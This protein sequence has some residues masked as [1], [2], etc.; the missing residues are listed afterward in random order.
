MGKLITMPNR[1]EERH[2]FDLFNQRF[3]GC[4]DEL[5]LQEQRERM[6]E[7]AKEVAEMLDRLDGELS[8]DRERAI[9]M[10]TECTGLL[11][12]VLDDIRCIRDI[13]ESFG[14]GRGRQPK[15]A[16]LSLKLERGI[17]YLLGMFSV[18]S[19]GE[20]LPVYN[21]KLIRRDIQDVLGTSQRIAELE[22]PVELPLA[23]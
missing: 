10:L 13:D 18:V 15:I 5:R 9:S 16:A 21:W 22:A 6:I 1:K 14:A 7:R 2:P 12:L 11:E 20:E 8:V 19:S 23:A 3:A 4:A 17:A